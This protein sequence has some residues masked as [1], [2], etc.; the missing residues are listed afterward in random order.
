MGDVEGGMIK[1]Y[2]IKISYHIKSYDIIDI[3]ATYKT[4]IKSIKDSSHFEIQ[5]FN[6]NTARTAWTTC[7]QIMTHRSQHRIHNI[8]GVKYCSINHFIL[9]NLVFL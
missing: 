7:L 4:L 9:K 1:I 3:I 5:K 6:K 2:C 8:H